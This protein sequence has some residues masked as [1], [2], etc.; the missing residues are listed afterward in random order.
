MAVRGFCRIL[1]NVARTTANTAQRFASASTMSVRDA[2]CA[3][4]DEEMA[5]DDRVF[6]LGE[7]VALYGGCY[8]VS[9][10][11]LEK[12]GKSR[13]LDTPITEMGFAGLAV[14]AA[15]AGMRPI[16]EFMTYNFSMQAIDQVVNSAAKTYYM[17]AG[18]IHVPIVFRGANGAGVG[19]AAQHS[20]D[21]SAWYA[22]CP[23]LKVVSPYSSEDAKGLLKASIRDDNPVVFMENEVLYTQQFPM[24]SNAMSSN[25]VLPIGVAKIE[26]SGKDATVVAYSAGMMR[27]LDGAKQL[28]K[29]GIDVEVINL[30]TLRPLDIE[31]IK[32][33]V[34]K[35]HHL[36]TIDNGW[37]FG[38]IGAE[39]VAQVIESEAFD[40][41]DAPIF[42]I[43]GVDVPMPY[44]LPLEI[45]A[46]PTA[47]DVVKMVKK[48]LNIK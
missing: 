29:E 45:A 25:F 24:S 17:S 11:L 40:Y 3:A 26:R 13:V 15:M 43:T 33:S 1:G 32:K 39:I 41:L 9:K 18:R 31:T 4:M 34:M 2:L 38:N 20:Q 10:G 16:C 37:P 46:Q 30:R 27:A 47:S 35:T 14:G 36:I 22:H 23:G 48:S 8:K 12:Y 19:V 44:A 7:E 6:L 5:R 21:F 28:K 42:R